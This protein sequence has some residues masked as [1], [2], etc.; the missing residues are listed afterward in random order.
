MPL[1]QW[2]VSLSTR[3]LQVSK[4]GMLKQVTHTLFNLVSSYDDTLTLPLSG[5]SV[6]PHNG[7]EPS[8]PSTMGGGIGRALYPTDKVLPV[9]ARIETGRFPEVH[10]IHRCFGA[11]PVHKVR[12]NLTMFGG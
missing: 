11:V 4:L 7:F 6:A 1:T 3:W 10:R 2:L 9:L 12:V 8:G 5:A